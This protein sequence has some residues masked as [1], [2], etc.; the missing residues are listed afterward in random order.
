[1]HQHFFRNQATVFF[2][3]GLILLSA[4]AKGQQHYIFVYNNL[5]GVAD[6][7]ALEVVA[8]TY[9]WKRTVAGREEYEIF[10]PP[11]SSNSPTLKFNMRTGSKELF[12]TYF[13]N[14]IFIQNDSYSFTEQKGKKYLLNEKTG[15]SILLKEDFWAFE[16]VGSRFIV[17]KFYPKIKVIKALPPKR[18]PIKKDKNGLLPPPKIE[19]LLPPPPISEIGTYD[20]AILNND[21]TMKIQL[22][23]KA[24]KFF[25]PYYFF[26]E[27][28]DSRIDLKAN[29]AGFVAGTGNSQT[30]YDALLKPIKKLALKLNPDKY[31]SKINHEDQEILLQE[32]NKIL[33]KKA[34]FSFPIYPSA[35][36]VGRQ[37]SAEKPSKPSVYL[38][39]SIENGITQVFLNH[40]EG[41]MDKLFETKHKVRIDE[42][43][44]E[45]YINPDGKTNFAGFEV[46]MKTGKLLLPVKYLKLLD[47]KVL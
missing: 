2:I 19:R 44:N 6:S 15:N 46:N 8:P 32:C 40:A 3:F 27:S 13:S 43:K 31:E 14:D 41:Y 28:S 22:H 29:P 24:S 1:M 21:T 12:D 4:I 5:Y 17:A 10:H 45:V 20:F 25:M 42:R 37:A 39:K 23:V 26:D 33:G 30:V 36:S 18:Q 9:D 16:N 47:L 34:V 11:T 38:S 7:N 35:P